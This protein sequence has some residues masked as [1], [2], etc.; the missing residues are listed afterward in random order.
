MGQIWKLQHRQVVC[1]HAPWCV[2]VQVFRHMMWKGQC[3]TVGVN[4]IVKGL[5]FEISTVFFG[6]Y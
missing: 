6:V 3:Y 2:L 4:K 1:P 5:T